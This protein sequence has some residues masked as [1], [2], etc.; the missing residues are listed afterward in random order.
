MAYPRR[1][2]HWLL[3]AVST[4]ETASIVVVSLLAGSRLEKVKNRL[5]CQ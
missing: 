1:P 2:K 5:E 4:S 3:I